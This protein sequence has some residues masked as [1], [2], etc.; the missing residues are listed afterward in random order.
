MMIITKRLIV[1]IAI[2]LAAACC[3]S[4]EAITYS[5]Q[6]AITDTACSI[7]RPCPEGLECFSFPERGMVC[8]K[9]NP[10]DYYQCPEGSQCVIAEM[11]PA[12]VICANKAAKKASD[13]QMDSH[14][15]NTVPDVSGEPDIY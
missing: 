10:C 14:I 9:P 4:E 3:N 1:M 8:A 2:L 15:I 5:P 7:D 13:E 6:E 11:Y 12:A